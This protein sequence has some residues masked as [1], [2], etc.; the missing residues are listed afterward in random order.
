MP[1]SFRLQRFSAPLLVVR[2][3]FV[4]RDLDQIIDATVFGIR[5]LLKFGQGFRV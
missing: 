1:P 2:N 4:C 3:Q 5:N